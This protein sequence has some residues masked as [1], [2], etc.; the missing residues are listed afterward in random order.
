MRL[1]VAVA[2]L[3]SEEL[4]TEECLQHVAVARVQATDWDWI[5]LSVWPTAGKSARTFV[6]ALAPLQAGELILEAGETLGF[7]SP[8]GVIAQAV[9]SADPAVQGILSE[10]PD[11]V[12]RYVR[13]RHERERV[14]FAR[15]RRDGLLSDVHDLVRIVSDTTWFGLRSL[16]DGLRGRRVGF[17]LGAQTAD[18]Q[19]LDFDPIAACQRDDIQIAFFS[20]IDKPTVTVRILSPDG[21]IENLGLPGARVAEALGV[22]L[23]RYYGFDVRLPLDVEVVSAFGLADQR[24]VLEAMKSCRS[25]LRAA[26]A[27]C[28][29]AIDAGIDATIS[30]LEERRRHATGRAAVVIVDKAG[31]PHAVG[32]VPTNEH[33]VLILVGKLETYIGRVLPVFRIWEHTSLVGIDALADIQLSRENV[34]ARQA[35]VE[36]EYQ[37]ENFFRHVHPIRQT[38]FVVCWS[39]GRLGNGRHSYGDGRVDAGGELAFEMRGGDWIRIL[40]FG[41]HLIRVL[42]LQDM[43]GLRVVSR[44]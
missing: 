8:H 30:L 10:S 33:E 32:S 20:S 23:S 42:V 21:S 43:P 5:T 3:L 13:E 18:I 16:P 28:E 22:A 29:E 37:L 35:T 6:S 36:F 9:A 31:T 44:A 24:A 34:P 39:T 15:L 26:R 38:E 2:R 12:Q 19:T 7:Y 11:E 27:H 17:A 41:E 14:I 25:N 1:A 4:A 40:D